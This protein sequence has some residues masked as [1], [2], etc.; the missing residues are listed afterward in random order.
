L[1]ADERVAVAVETFK[2]KVHTT[3]T[4]LAVTN[5]IFEVTGLGRLR[6]NRVSIFTSATCAPA[7]CKT[8]ALQPL[9]SANTV[10]RSERHS[11]VLQLSWR[12]LSG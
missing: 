3:R 4:A 5:K 12:G 7:R 10:R 1:T 11:Q 6:R 8:R 9:K 2:S